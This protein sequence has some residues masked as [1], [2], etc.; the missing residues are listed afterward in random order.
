MSN[1]TGLSPQDPNKYLG[2]NVYLAVQVTR[3]RQPTGADYRQPETGKLYPFG[4][5]WIVGKDPTTGV[6]GEIWYLSKIVANVAFWIM[7]NGGSIGSDSFQVQDATAPGVNP[8]IPDGTGLVTINGA[9]VANHSVPVESHTRAL[10]TYN[11]EV[12]YA[13]SAA[14]T[15][16]TK[17]GLA[18]FNSAM[19]TVDADGFVSLSGGGLAIDGITVD[20]FTGPGTQPVTPD[21]SGNIIVT[22]GQVA[23]GTIG[24]N[25]IRSNSLALNTYTMQIQRAASAA[26]SALANNGIS[27][28]NSGDFIVDSNAY[29]SNIPLVS[30][31][32]SNI[33]IA[34]SAGTFTVQGFDGTALSASNPGVIWLQDKTTPGR[35]KKY[36]VTANQTFTD[37]AGGTTAT[38]RWNLTAGVNWA[39]DMLFFLY[40]VGNDAEDTIA[41]MISRIPHATVSPAAASIGKTGALVNTGQ[42]DFFSLP[43]ITVAD[44]DANPCLL[45]G[46]FRMQF[47]GATNSWTVQ[48]LTTTDGI[49]HYQE[50]K[51]FS[52][53]KGQLGAASGKFFADNG[54]T[55]P[56]M[57]GGIS[58]YTIDRF[59]FVQI[60]I[61]GN[62]DTAGVGA[63]D[64]TLITPFQRTSGLTHGYGFW[65]AAG[66]SPGS[67]IVTQFGASTNLFILVYNAFD[68][69][70]FIKTAGVQNA[71]MGITAALRL[72]GSFTAS[73]T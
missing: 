1:H 63:V 29:V 37:G 72:E 13:T 20:A 38:Q 70:G 61:G 64:C 16:A 41:F 68:V 3:N 66:G 56:D 51:V 31:Q 22:G 10:N 44:Y 7:L 23:A 11:I 14:S 58:V 47:V 49:S 34:Y 15:D 48:T 40:A 25:A 60:N 30:A 8:V 69:L 46:S 17:S 53:A 5:F 24:A 42:G 55:A 18:H 26:S 57:S 12:Q 19:F 45:L 28:Y 27:S 2:A 36:L 39:T 73:I 43:N 9:V 65:V 4:S 35:L 52:V 50:G 59:G 62:I 21:G 33:G 71:D 54:G 67:T 6:Q 32:Y